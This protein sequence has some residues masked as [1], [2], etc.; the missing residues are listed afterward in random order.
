[1]VSIPLSN[2]GFLGG[3]S[4]SFAFDDRAN[5]YS[6]GE[7]VAVLVLKSLR[8]A[9]RDNDPIRTIIRGTASNQDGRTPVITQPSGI[10]QERLLREIYQRA[11]L[12]PAETGYFEAHGTGTKVGDPIESK[13]ISNVFKDRKGNAPLFVG[14]VKTNIGHLEGCSGIA[15]VIKTVLILERGIIPPNVWLE[16]PNPAINEIGK[17]IQVRASCQ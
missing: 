11:E 13:A 9:L 6:R 7:G 5:G 4:I 15:G 8:Q 3:D 2:L 14:A 17:T 16:K 1:M 12:D 10:A